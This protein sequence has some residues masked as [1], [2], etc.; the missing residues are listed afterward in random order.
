[1]LD[2][3]VAE[4]FRPVLGADAPI[5]VRAYD[6]SVSEPATG[7][8]TATV[9]VRSETALAYLAGS[10]NSLG[11]ARA[12]VSGHLDVDG[13]LYDALTA[14]SELAISDVSPA[15][16]ATM[17]L[18][19]AP[20]RLRHRRLGP[21]PEEHRQR[22]LMHS[23]S[24]DAEA[25]AHHYDVSNRFYELVLGP[26]MAY[27]CAAYPDETSSLE[28]A[29]FAKHALVADKLALK[30]GMR[31][32]DVGCGWGQMSMHAAEHHGVQVLGVTLSRDQALWAQKE[33]ARRG[34]SDLVEIRH[35]DYRD[36]T[37][38]GFDAVSSIGLT[39]HIG[40]SQLRTYFS[41][42]YSKLRPGGR[43]LNHCITRPDDHHRAHADPFIDRYVFPDGEL[44]PIG[45]L[46]SRMNAAGFEIRHEENLREHYSKTLKAWSANLEANWDECV[47]EAG[48]GR[49]RVWKL[50]MPAC[51]VG[52]D[53]NNIQL[54]QVLG[55]KL[56][57]RGQS[58]FPL[59]PAY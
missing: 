55:V 49:A 11:L 41:F 9:D 17:A 46:V 19:L 35:A 15:T 53:L 10:P 52:F 54:H 38:T 57:D 45:H 36:V 7:T 30:P 47:A 33:V 8:P 31:M 50:Y 42:L 48:E 51:A 28:E 6:G 22:G 34:L 32:L 26:S 12:F 20:I 13:D 27:T 16:L 25:I 18:R 14:V 39:E 5:T 44:L 40:R 1:M 29:Q 56:D 58:G 24:R 2:A 23:K 59:R 43:L 21:P 4:L 37:E 3:S